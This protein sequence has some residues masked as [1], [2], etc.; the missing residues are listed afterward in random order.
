MNGYFQLIEDNGHTSV[1]LYP[2][3]DGGEKIRV[4]EVMEY[5]TSRGLVCDL[6][7]LNK[8]ILEASEPTI[9]KIQMA[10][11]PREDE[12]YRLEIS[13]D[14][15]R[16]TARFYAPSTNGNH[17]STA[18][19]VNDLFYKK[20]VFGIK[21]DELDQFFEHPQYCTDIIVAE[22]KPPRHGLDAKI[23]YYFNTDLRAKPTLNE[24]GSVD[25]FHLN[26]ISHCQQGDLLAKLI[27]ADPGEEGCNCMGEKLK[28]RDVK[29]AVLKFG[30]NIELSEDKL[31]IT[32]MV[33]GHV[34]LTD[35]KVFV[36]DILEVEN[37]DNSTGN[38]EYKGNVKINGNVGSNFEVKATGN[39]IVNGVVEGAHIIAGGDIIIARGMN[40]MGKGKLEAGGNIVAKF[41][42]NSEAMAG[43]YVSTESILHS[44]VM[45]GTEV[46][47]TGKRGFITGG[48]V[49]AT[50]S[51]TVK[52]LGSNMGAST[53][54]EVG[55][56]P[57]MKVKLQE[58]QKSIVEIQKILKQITPLVV[59]FQQKL[60]MGVELPADKKEYVSSLIKLKE[61]KEA[62]LEKTLKKMDEL[63]DII[64]DKHQAQV[65]VN[66]EA[67]Q[68]T[69][70]VIAEVS[71]TL[72]TSVKYCRF[73]KERGD[74]VIA[75]MN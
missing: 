73:I 71:R 12:C 59:A 75:S 62:E 68:G 15:M 40:G 58:Y 43:G 5:L 11:C 17:L 67:F 6:S 3:T 49:C 7:V 19:F 32:S 27:P 51:I 46:S 45:A 14:K 31:S 2:E 44:T 10:P 65:I 16:V 52:T 36:S 61:L 74:V 18:E 25:F 28:P 1:K 22:G 47:V 55:A 4:N 13:E 64:E 8:T 39:V 72:Q 50:N 34:T 54:V 66:G 53:V 33:N 56:D 9:L 35:D 23:E 70:I 41:M 42:E 20:V 69:K 63:Q 57:S 37:V 29:N 26:T 30:R 48:R 21:R 38:I 24:D 60:A